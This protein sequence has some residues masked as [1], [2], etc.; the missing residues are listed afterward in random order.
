[1]QEKTYRLAKFFHRFL[2]CSA[3]ALVAVLIFKI[4]VPE[5]VFRFLHLS[6]VSLVGATLFLPLHWMWRFI[7]KQHVP[8]RPGYSRPFLWGL[9]II[10]VGFVELMA[11]SSI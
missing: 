1:M 8:F 5:V 11:E 10:I 3:T 7:C 6:W 2:F 4:N 9:G